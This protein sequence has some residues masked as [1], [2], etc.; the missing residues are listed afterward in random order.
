RRDGE[1]G[2]NQP[3]ITNQRVQQQ[4]TGLI[5]QKQQGEK[6]LTNAPTKERAQK[7]VLLSAGKP[8]Q[9]HINHH[10][11]NNVFEN[12]VRDEL[13]VSQRKLINS[14]KAVYPKTINEQR[15]VQEQPVTEQ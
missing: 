1:A 15:P 10:V 2:S 13:T 7:D 14:K 6:E 5:Q 9:K 4:Q 11:K 3:V 8:V 12:D